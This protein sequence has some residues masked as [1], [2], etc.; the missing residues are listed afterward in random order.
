MRRIGNL[1]GIAALLLTSFGVATAETPAIPPMQNMPDG[2]ITSPGSGMGMT[3]GPARMG[4]MGMMGDHVE[5]RIAFLKTELKITEAQMPPWN[6]FADVLR[7]NARRMGAMPVIM[8]QSGMMGHD[9]AS[10]NAPD[11]L[12][13]MEKMMTAM[14]EAVKATKAALAPLYAVLTDEQKKVADQLIHGPMG[15]GR[16]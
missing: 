4:M 3:G 15:L 13:R 14:L 8:M 9:G 5:G 11:R 16:M 10:V 2:G 6:A 12:D 1:A 7:E